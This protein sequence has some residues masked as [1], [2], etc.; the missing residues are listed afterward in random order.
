VNDVLR[1][2]EVNTHENS[3]QRPYLKKPI[4]KALEVRY[5]GKYDDLL[6]YIEQRSSEGHFDCQLD[7]V[8]DEENRRFIRRAQNLMI[9][10]GLRC[11]TGVNSGKY[12]R[13]FWSKPVLQCTP[14]C[15]IFIS[16][17]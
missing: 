5:G 13:F 1:K 4:R 15:F 8:D 3:N 16:W 10:N 14:T 11:W 2:F 7:Y 9:D 6:A 17:E 12:K